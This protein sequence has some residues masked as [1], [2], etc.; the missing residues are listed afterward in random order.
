[1]AI[2]SGP[3]T[4]EATGHHVLQLCALQ[5]I[6]PDVDRRFVLDDNISDEIAAMADIEAAIAGLPGSI[7]EAGAKLKIALALLPDECSDVC[8]GLIEGARHDLCKSAGLPLPEGDLVAALSQRGR[9][10]VEA[11]GDLAPPVIA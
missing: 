7:A 11:H 6:E 9:R 1:V 8:A 5:R 10:I 3:C 4:W 2:S